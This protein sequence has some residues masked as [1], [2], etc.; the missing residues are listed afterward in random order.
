[1]CENYTQMC[2]PRRARFYVTFL[3]RKSIPVTRMCIPTKFI[4]NLMESL[5]TATE[6]FP[7]PAEFVRGQGRYKNVGTSHKCTS[8]RSGWPNDDE[9][10][11]TLAGFVADSSATVCN[12]S[13]WLRSFA[14]EQRPLAHRL[15]R[16]QEERTT[17]CRLISI[18]LLLCVTD[19]DRW[20]YGACC[21][22]VN[23]GKTWRI[24]R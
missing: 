4:P 8:P 16:F 3:K 21:V 19:A 5:W 12:P 18:K 2:W 11:Q 14:G 15:T 22:T 6:E 13:W 1:M 24:A 9:S 7:P 17:K 23:S 10:Q 20:E